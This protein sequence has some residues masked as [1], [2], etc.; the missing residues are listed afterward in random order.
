LARPSEWINATDQF[1]Q[2]GIDH[3][4]VGQVL[5]FDYEGSRNDFRIVDTD[6]NEVWIKP[7]RTYTYQE[8][9]AKWSDEGLEP[10]ET[11]SHKVE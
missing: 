9:E 10:H 8:A 1:T 5:T 11:K 4:E 7:I 3:L 6:N 2:A